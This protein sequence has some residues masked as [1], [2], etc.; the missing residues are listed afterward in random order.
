MI[1]TDNTI[2]NSAKSRIR[3]MK[4]I[5]ILILAIISL[6]SCKKDEHSIH[7]HDNKEVA[8]IPFIYSP[9]GHIVVKCII[10][11]DTFNF[12]LDNRVEYKFNLS[13]N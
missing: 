8:E 3:L 9:S 11:K 2:K 7:F 5:V 13:R 1:A 6:W 4:H 12:V 10:K